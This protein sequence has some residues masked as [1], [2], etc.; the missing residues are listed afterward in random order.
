M[1][2][3]P[4]QA[5]LAAALGVTPG[6]VT[7]WKTWG[8]FPDRHED[9]WDEDEVREW[10]R[11]ARAR[12]RLAGKTGGHGSSE[13][14]LELGLDE[15]ELAELRVETRDHRRAITRLRQIQ[16]ESA[17]LRL[18]VER[19]RYVSRLEVE[20]MLRDRVT[21]LVRGLDSLIQEEKADLAAARTAREVEAILRRAHHRLRERYSRPL[22]LPAAPA[23][24]D[25]PRSEPVRTNR[26]R[27]RR[28]AAR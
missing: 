28:V 5:E 12:R 3:H 15:D 8:E 2:R 18:D 1:P 17:Q 14:Q 9:G 22:P 16:A 11:A 13:T 6:A 25:A 19:G 10:H 21:E 24:D 26:T 4:T 20:Q 7:Q 23:E 27:K